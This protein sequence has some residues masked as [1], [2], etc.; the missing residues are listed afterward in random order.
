MVRFGSTAPHGRVRGSARVVEGLGV[1]GSGW[2][3]ASDTSD[4]FR[5]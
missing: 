5:R 2:D 3:T 1:D 4:L